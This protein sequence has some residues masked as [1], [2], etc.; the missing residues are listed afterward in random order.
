MS[1]DSKPRLTKNERR[2]QAREQARVAREQEKKREK[3]RRLYIQGG[4][5]LGVVA[6]L[7]VVG[8]FIAQS[9]KPAGP[10]PKNMASGSVVFGENLQVVEG[11]ALQSGEKRTAPEVDR[12]KLPIDVTI[13]ADYMCPACGSFEQ[14]YGAK[15]E[16][17]VGSGDITLGVYPLNFLD[18][19]SKGA[20]YSTRAANIFGCVVE[21]QP[22]YAFKLHNL[23]L[24]AEVQPAEG[25]TGLTDAQ[26][27]DQA[28]AA[29]AEVDTDLKRCVNSQRFASFFSANT[30]AATETGVL[31]LAED[32]Q[33]VG[34][35]DTQTGKILEMQ[36]AGDPQRLVQTPLVIVNGEQW[37]PSRDGDL[38][39][40]ILKVKS[41]LTQKSDASE[42]DA[43]E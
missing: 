27:L 5:V 38:E 2:E 24:S 32:A 34:K 7:A 14:N 17:Y 19:Q 37:V 43:E 13:Y 11:P 9:M 29:G 33:L 42:K 1:N 16:N 3:R 36:K 15:L 4:V 22:E 20:N 10:G 21:Q 18:G 26:L 40:Y 28:A 23:L 39:L 6:V 35:T 31:G 41:E 8:L 12:S 25:T 30:K